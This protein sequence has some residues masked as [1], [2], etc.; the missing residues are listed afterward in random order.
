VANCVLAVF[1][2]ELS[3][4][5]KME[6]E[7]ALR[8][9][10]IVNVA[11]IFVQASLFFTS[12]GEIY[13]IYKL[14]FGSS[15][16][17]S[18]DYL[19]IARFSGMQVEP[20]TYANYVSYLLAIFIFTSTFGLRTYLVSIF[21]LLSI[22]LTN[23]ASAMYFALILSLLILRFW[24]DKINKRY[25][26]VFIFTILLYF[27]FS[28]IFEHLNARFLQN[29]DGSLSLRMIGIKGYLS[30]TFESKVLGLGFE[31]E[32]CIDCHYQDIGVIFNVISSGGLLLL[33][34]L[35]AIC[36]RSIRENGW[37]LAGLIM[38]ISAYSKMHYYEAPV[39][40]LFLFS[41]THLR[42][43]RVSHS[44]KNI[45]PTVNRSTA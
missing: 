25:I 33:L 6:F 22:L 1:C 20:G 12:G 41:M 15:S 45:F 14:L 30:T 19:N 43:I 4:V 31:Y 39:W 16:R 7:S 3:K 5:W 26:V 28:N 42:R 40:L 21:T 9:L 38:A 24:G 36:Y 23:S 27:S 32:P 18:E 8:W 2:F 34:M 37:M 10:I 11:A 35:S 17:F 13:D 44:I 29:D